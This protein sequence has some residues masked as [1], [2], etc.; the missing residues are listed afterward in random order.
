MKQ[1]VNFYTD[2]YHPKTDYFSL[3]LCVA[4]LGALA[5]IMLFVSFGQY[6]SQ[7]TVRNNLELARSANA[8]WGDQIKQLKATI[9]A[10][11]RDPQL[12]SVAIQLEND[13][14]NKLTLRQFLQQEVPGNVMGFSGYLE[15][16]ARFHVSGLR[17]TRISLRDGGKQIQLQGEVLSGDFVTNYIDGLGQSKHFEGNEFRQL[18]LE[19]K[20]ERVFPD[21][22][23]DGQSLIFEISTVGSVK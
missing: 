14:K 18:K 21:Q 19:R 7:L 22:L 13:Q 6:L 23:P 5:I 8:E 20:T 4:Y 10:R 11:A 12:E 2:F 16:L 9:V 17:L 3:K 1:R 15:D